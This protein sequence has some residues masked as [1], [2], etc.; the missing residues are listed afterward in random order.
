MG[1]VMN[2]LKNPPGVFKMDP[3]EWTDIKDHF[4]SGWG[5]ISDRV[6]GNNLQ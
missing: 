1:I 6:N 5:C 3:I 4:I 2:E